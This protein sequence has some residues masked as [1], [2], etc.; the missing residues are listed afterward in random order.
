MFTDG[1]RFDRIET[2]DQN[3]VGFSKRHVLSGP[4]RDGRQND[5]IEVCEGG[6]PLA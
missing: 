1:A 4:K 2:D 6:T 3:G 5:V